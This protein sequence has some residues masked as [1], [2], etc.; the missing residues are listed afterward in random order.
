MR[1]HE[2]PRT[3]QRDH[4]LQ[5]FDRCVIQD[6][7][8]WN[9]TIDAWHPYGLPADVNLTNSEAFFGLDPSTPGRLPDDLDAQLA[10]NA[11][12]HRT[13]PLQIGCGSMFGKLRNWMGLMGVS[14]IQYDDP[15]LFA[16]MIATT[17]DCIVATLE[18]VL[19][20]AKAAGVT[21][22]YGSMWEDMSYAQGPLLGLPAFETHC[23]PQYKRISNLLASYGTDII[24]LD[25]DGDSRPLIPGW[26]ESGVNVAFP[27]EAGG[28]IPFCDHRVPPD[29][30]LDHYLHYVRRAKQVWGK[31]A[32]D[33][34]P[35]GEIDTSAPMYGKPYDFRAFLADS[36][37]SH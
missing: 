7:S 18:A 21:F 12:A 22:D 35:T 26:L 14:Y 5:P 15:E 25:S 30:S 28:F 10:A 19:G 17:G 31:G 32:A 9:E 20:R 16:E 27:L 24:M 36:P 11:D 1:F 37:A 33:L 2:R 6:F 4:A 13:W 23:V 3:I 8:Y 29:V 34:L